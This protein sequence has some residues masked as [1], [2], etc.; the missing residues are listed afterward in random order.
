[1]LDRGEIVKFTASFL[2]PRGQCANFRETIEYLMDLKYPDIPFEFV[3]EDESGHDKRYYLLL[4]AI[5]EH[6]YRLGRDCL[7]A[8][9]ITST[10]R[11]AETMV[12]TVLK[13]LNDEIKQGGCLDTYLQDQLVVFQ[14]LAN[15]TSCINSGT[16]ASLHTKTARW[17]VEQFSNAKWSQEV[18]KATS[19]GDKYRKLAEKTTV[20]DKCEGIGF[21]SGS[22]EVLHGPDESFP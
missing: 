1:M 21:V 2:V 11:I 14:S 13:E 10:D 3:T 8:T 12:M 4:V 19:E 18:S 9:K 16:P 15:G 22:H 6:G 7:Y 20:I 17:V 5:T